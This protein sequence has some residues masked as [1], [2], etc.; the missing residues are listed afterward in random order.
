MPALAQ[1]GKE[2]GQRVLSSGEVARLLRSLGRRGH[3]GASRFMLLT[4]ARREEVV[5]AAWGEIDLTKGEWTIPASRRKDTR[6]PSRR[7]RR[8]AA[9]HVVPLSKQAQELLESLGPASSPDL[10]FVGGRE[11]KL[12]N[13][14]R[15][16]AKLEKEIGIESV[17]PHALRRTAAT[18]AAILAA[19]RMSFRLC[20]DIVRSAARWLLATTR[21]DSHPRSPMRYSESGICWRRWRRERPMKP[22]RS[23]R[24][25]HDS[26]CLFRSRDRHQISRS[27]ASLFCFE[28]TS[29]GD[30]PRFLG[31]FDSIRIASRCVQGDPARPEELLARWG[32]R[33]AET[34][35][36]QHDAVDDGFAQQ[37]PLTRHLE[38]RSNRTHC[39]RSWPVPVRA[40]CARSGR[41]T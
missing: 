12:T 15:W 35:D 25:P 22:R 3:D 9:D 19:R 6:A 33:S 8:A 40:G 4:A 11:A 7:R 37:R 24:D 14:P 32:R 21:V 36:C 31:H 38:N 29:A 30:G 2:I 20:S 18:L 26:A 34:L 41:E 28:K 5:G 17:T 27:S 10:V 1:D 16:S 23:S 13:W 39:C